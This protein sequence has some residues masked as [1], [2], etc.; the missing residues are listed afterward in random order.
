MPGRILQQGEVAVVDGAFE[1]VYDPTALQQLFPSIDLV[2]RDDSGAGLADTVLITLFA[3]GDGDAGPWYRATTV[4]LQ[5]E[6]VAV[7]GRLRPE[8]PRLPGGRVSP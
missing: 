5:G 8:G 6:L 2:G 4:S 3:D 7:G 1:L